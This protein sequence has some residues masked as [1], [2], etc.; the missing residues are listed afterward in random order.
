MRGALLLREIPLSGRGGECGWLAWESLSC[1]LVEPCSLA[2]KV[3]R[4]DSKC[5]DEFSTTN[6]QEVIPGH[7]I[8]RKRKKNRVV[9][10]KRPSMKGKYSGFLVKSTDRGRD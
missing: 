10:F 7:D 5:A 3:S 1:V 8:Y 6:C 2:Q 4:S 9:I